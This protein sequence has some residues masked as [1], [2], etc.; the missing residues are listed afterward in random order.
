MNSWWHS[1]RERN[2][3]GAAPPPSRLWTLL[4][5]LENLKTTWVQT[6]KQSEKLQ[7]KLLQTYYFF[8][9][10]TTKTYSHSTIFFSKKNFEFPPPLIFLNKYLLPR[11]NFSKFFLWR[12]ERNDTTKKY[13]YSP[14]FHFMGAINILSQ[15]IWNFPK[16]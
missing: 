4:R 15:R 13:I 3:S 12:L 2:S 7:W 8:N 14:V 11:T 6:L 9:F 1:T 16:W 5:L 10:K